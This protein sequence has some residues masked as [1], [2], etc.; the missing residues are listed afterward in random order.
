MRFTDI[1]KKYD[2]HVVL[3]DFSLYVEPGTICCITGPSG[4]GKTTL[5]N[6]ASGLEKQDSGTIEKD[7]SEEGRI[8][9]LFQD[10]RLLPWLTVLDNVTVPLCGDREKAK[11]ALYKVG[12]GDSLYKY[13]GQLSGGMRQRTAIARAF[14]YQSPLLLLDEP[15]QN[16]DKNNRSELIRLFL[17]IHE[18]NKRTVLWVTHDTQEAEILHAPLIRM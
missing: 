3:D 9:Y 11:S 17:K 4:C 10:P 14:S 2:N 13:P 7:K 16:L 1:C 12:L 5:L 18:E 6:I 8:S 15:F